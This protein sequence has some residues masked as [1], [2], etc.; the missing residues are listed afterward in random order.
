MPHRIIDTFKRFVFVEKSIREEINILNT[1]RVLY[2]SPIVVMV[3]ILHV[4]FFSFTYSGTSGNTDLWK[5][6]LSIAHACMMLWMVACMILALYLKDKPN[7]RLLN[8]FLKYLMIAG[9]GAGGIAI[10]VIDQL[11]TTNISPFIILSVIVATSLFNHPLRSLLYYTI[12]Y[13]AFYFLIGIHNPSAEVLFSNRV[14]G[15]A[16]V[17]FCFVLSVIMWRHQYTNIRQRSYINDQRIKL[18]QANQ[19]LNRMAFY[20]SL[21]GLPNRQHFDQVL[22]KEIAMNSRMAY[23]SYLIMLDIDWFKNIN[24][25]YGHPIGDELLI[26]IACLLSENIRI[27]D[28]LC[29][30]GGEEF[31]L[32]LPHTEAEEALVVAEK[33]RRVLESHTFCIN[34]HIIHITASLGVSRLSYTSDPQ[35]IAQY[36]KVDN[37]LYQAKQCGRN[38]VK[39]A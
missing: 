38:C 22:Q 17:V 19:K 25:M 21:T 18:E 37:A 6:E 4:F 11:V 1:R 28:T 12:I 23:N 10:V 15:F 35:L 9:F 29:R 14:N 34:D 33:L 36:A 5:E 31:L 30:L 20:D 16:T 24:D 27:Y 8:Y 7:R 39:S 2:C 32:L 26:S 13:T 3:N